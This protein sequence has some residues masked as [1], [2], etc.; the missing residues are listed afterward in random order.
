MT[1]SFMNQFFMFLWI[2]I[3]FIVIGNA[4]VIDGEDYY[5]DVTIQ[6]WNNSIDGFYT[7]EFNVTG[8][9]IS[10]DSL[11]DEMNLWSK[12]VLIPFNYG[13]DDIALALAKRGARGMVMGSTASFLKGRAGYLL[14]NPRRPLY[15]PAT[16]V[17][18]ED[19]YKIKDLL[20][21]SDQTHIGSFFSGNDTDNPY[22][23]TMLVLG[24]ISSVFLCVCAS[25]IV[26]LSFFVLA[27]EISSRG[28]LKLTIKTVL[29]LFVLCLGI[30]K[31]AFSLGDFEGHSRQ[32]GWP[33]I[34]FYQMI[35]IPCSIICILLL[36]L[37]W[38]E[39]LSGVLVEKKGI[40]DSTKIPFTIVC[41][42]FAVLIVV[43][44]FVASIDPLFLNSAISYLG[45][46]YSLIWFS[47]CIFHLVTSC[48]I[49]AQ[50]KQ[51]K[52]SRKLEH[53]LTFLVKV[54]LISVLD[55]ICIV[56][57]I[58]IISV[59]VLDTPFSTVLA[60]TV[61]NFLAT[62]SPFIIL[63]LFNWNF[64]EILSTSKTNNSSK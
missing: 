10:V 56:L 51:I 46:F 59:G 16:Q 49:D 33:V 63:T 64:K 21:T 34:V 50:L 18:Q 29:L 61:Y 4:L 30:L 26:L 55:I 36:S 42:V 14:G 1:K 19:Y 60:I 43:I 12:I 23:E 20:D 27:L 5:E 8:E 57:L 62:V 47:L 37:Y 53:A 54:V 9:L 24:P 52:K 44:I 22:H 15:F 48:M 35:N 58:T 3:L 2:L 31:L 28:Y 11:S 41:I 25:V 7:G 13:A 45:M 40:L 39:T 17:S 6:F 32:I 38:F